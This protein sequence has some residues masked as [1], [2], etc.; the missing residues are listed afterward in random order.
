MTHLLI[1]LWLTAIGVVAAAPASR[2]LTPWGIAALA[3]ALGTAIYIVV[4]AFLAATG[5][6]SVIS[7]LMIA[8][9]A[10]LIPLIAA[11]TN[12]RARI[13]ARTVLRGAGLALG[14]TTVV[15][16]VALNVHTTRLTNDSYRY[17]MWASSLD[18]TGGLEA[19][20]SLGLVKQQLAAPLIQATG[21]FA[22][23]GYSPVHSPLFGAA[24]LA[25]IGWLATRIMG[26]DRVPVRWQVVLLA[27]AGLLLLTT[28]RFVFHLTYINGHMLVAM[29]LL[30]AVG[31][32]W[33]SVIEDEH[34]FLYLAGIAFAAAAIARAELLIVIALFLVP[35][36]AHRDLSRRDRLVITMPAAIVAVAWFG[37]VLP[38]HASE[39][40]FGTTP[41]YGNA[42]LA[43]LLVVFASIAT[44]V[45]LRRLVE[46]APWLM[47]GGTLVLLAYY[48]NSDPELMRLSMSSL[49]ANAAYVGAWGFFWY[50]VSPLVAATMVWGRVEA[51]RLL[52]FGIVGFFVTLP[53]MAYLREGAYRVG[54]G[55]SGNRMLMH[56]VPLLVVYLVVAAGR[57]AADVAI[58]SDSPALTTS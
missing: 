11:G 58:P 43:L 9:I 42:A 30:V 21:W 35:I 55:D 44:V 6:F 33:L 32:T 23:D 50:V 12:T 39:L 51:D 57:A 34:R 18:Q 16:I 24:T 36:L 26:R 46:L 7:T 22:G 19:V 17:L 14:L 2:W 29:L 5:L 4:G 15:A 38:P 49:G 54:S 52:N 41:T 25:T 27:S 1:A 31:V 10:S 48:V 37:L 56:I 47:L 53:L 28:N 13:R 40:K 20:D 8:T 45:R 3:P